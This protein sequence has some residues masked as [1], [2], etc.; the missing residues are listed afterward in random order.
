M[1]DP[2]VKTDTSWDQ[3]GRGEEGGGGNGVGV[4][5]FWVKKGFQ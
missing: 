1:R 2:T 5:T 4:V 3:G